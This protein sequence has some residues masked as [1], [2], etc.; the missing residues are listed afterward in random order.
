MRVHKAHPGPCF[1]GLTLGRE[2]GI[3]YTLCKIYCVLHGVFK[4]KNKEMGYK[5]CMDGGMCADFRVARESSLRGDLSEEL[6][7]G[8]HRV[9]KP[10]GQCLPGASGVRNSEVASVL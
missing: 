5:V 9:G 2:R 1:H 7:R 10:F 8:G 6:R 4:E 3:I